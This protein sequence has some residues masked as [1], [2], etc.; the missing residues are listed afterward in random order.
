MSMTQ[1]LILAALGALGGIATA[2]A[3]VVARSR[4]AK[5]RTK[6]RDQLKALGRRANLDLLGPNIPSDLLDVASRY[7][8]DQRGIEL[9]DVMLG[10]D[11]EGRVWLARRKAAGEHHQV[12]GFEIRGELNVRG[13][14]IEPVARFEPMPWYLRPF[15][16]RTPIGRL[17]LRTVWECDARRVVDDLTRRAVDRWMLEVARSCEPDGKTPI[18]IEI[19]GDHAWV[20]SLVP[21]DGVALHEFLRRAQEVRRMVLDEVRRRPATL[22]TPAERRTDQE[23]V[24]EKAAKEDT[25][26]VFAVPATEGA[27]LDSDAKTVQLSALDLLREVPDPRRSTKRK[28]VNA[29][30][31][32]EIPEPEERVTLIRA[33]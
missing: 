14:H 12:F 19:H 28:A 13:L 22:S 6:R 26:P 8:G 32:F 27:V 5:R 18:G 21:L 25:R 10:S 3:F 20:H 4:A 33:R 11:R 9:E 30:D 15:R 31:E 1:S 2:V 7:R 16:S 23:K 29:D 24:E 17:Q